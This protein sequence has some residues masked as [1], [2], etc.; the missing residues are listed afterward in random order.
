VPGGDVADANAVFRYYG[1]NT[2]NVYNSKE[3]FSSYDPNVYKP[4]GTS[5]AAAN[6]LKIDCTGMIKGDEISELRIG[7]AISCVTTGP[8]GDAAN[9]NAI[10]RYR[11]SNVLDVY[12]NSTVAASWDTNWGKFGDITPVN[13]CAPITRGS[14]LIVNT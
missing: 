10:F 6:I 2:G 14:T 7:S 13:N 8:G 5:N 11:G 1:N 12:P 4:D 3:I 9:A